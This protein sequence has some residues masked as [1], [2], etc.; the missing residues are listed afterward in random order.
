MMPKSA[1]MIFRAVGGEDRDAVA[2]L[3]LA[4]GERARNADGQR[5]DLRVGELARR[6][7]AAEIDDRDLV[8]VEIAVDQVAE[9]CEPQH[10]HAP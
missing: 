7:L 6:L 5:L 4:R 3:E 2:A 8:R 1:A 9:I 10:P